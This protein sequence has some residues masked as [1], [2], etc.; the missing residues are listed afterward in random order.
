MK[1]LTGILLPVPTP[2][3]ADSYPA[4]DE[5]A[6]NL[7][8]WTTKGVVGYV[9]LGSTG[10]RVHLDDREYV[11]IIEAARGSI[12]DDLAFIVGAGQQSTVGTIREIKT[13]AQAGAD[14][15]LVI[16]PYFYR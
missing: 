16:T 13:A 15:V 14:A 10:E 4:F 6:L 2:F 7:S 1:N 12:A 9:V 3:T 5:L 8:N 11:Q